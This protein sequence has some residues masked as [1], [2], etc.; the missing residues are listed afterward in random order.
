MAMLNKKNDTGAIITDDLTSAVRGI[1]HFVQCRSGVIICCE[2]STGVDSLAAARLY[3]GVCAHKLSRPNV[4][5]KEAHV[6]LLEK[7]R[8]TKKSFA[9]VVRKGTWQVLL[10]Y[11]FT[12]I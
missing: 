8:N 3:A 4:I 1:V 11:L 12:D 9:M 7:N 5:A 6:S 2:H 10:N